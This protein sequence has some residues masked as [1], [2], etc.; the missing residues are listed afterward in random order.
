MRVNILYESIMAKMAK[1][2]KRGSILSQFIPLKSI[3][4][5]E[6]S[7]LILNDVKKRNDRR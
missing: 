5:L 4:E 2:K 7:K 3:N 6:D 1:V